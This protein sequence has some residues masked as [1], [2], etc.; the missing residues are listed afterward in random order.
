[1][2]LAE[3]KT[4]LVEQFFTPAS[5]GLPTE[6]LSEIYQDLKN[7]LGSELIVESTS[8]GIHSNEPSKAFAQFTKDRESV[9]AIIE[10]DGMKKK[11][12]FAAA[13]RGT[14]IAYMTLTQEGRE[15]KKGDLKTIKD[16][17]RQAKNLND[18]IDFH[19]IT[20]G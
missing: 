9:V 18:E 7:K 5:S 3:L 16:A 14:Q 6:L 2:K 4:S 10:E 13:K 20:L 12:L 8:P 15:V 19:V 17:L 1:M 11:A